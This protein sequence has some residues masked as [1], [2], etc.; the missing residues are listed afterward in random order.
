MNVALSAIRQRHADMQRR[1]DEQ[2]EAEFSL[3]AA[4][5]IDDV[6]ALLAEVDRLGAQ[7]QRAQHAHDG[8]VNLLA[9]GNTI[10]A[11]DLSHLFDALFPKWSETS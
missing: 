8:L 6:P 5:A 11:A 4:E 3:A 1:L 9:D 7:I 10:T 2:D